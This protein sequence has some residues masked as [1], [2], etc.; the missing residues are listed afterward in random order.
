MLLLC[1]GSTS[2][3]HGA[4]WRSFSCSLADA[5]DWVLLW[6]PSSLWGQLCACTSANC[7]ASLFLIL[8][9]A[10]WIPWTALL[11]NEDV[12]VASFTVRRAPSSGG[13]DLPWHRGKSKPGCTWITVILMTRRMIRCNTGQ[14]HYVHSRPAIAAR[15]S[16]IYL[17][18]LPC[19]DSALCMAQSQTPTHSR[20][21]QRTHR[22]PD[23][24][25]QTNMH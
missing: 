18:G 11:G 23:T 22:P 7:F 17:P 12:I 13:I 8:H 10:K 3:I 6:V 15:Q 1:H 2:R 14:P 16:L 5:L 25:G 9:I 19:R 21:R 24:A 20:C 4:C